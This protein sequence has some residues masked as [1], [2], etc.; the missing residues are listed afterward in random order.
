MKLRIVLGMLFILTLTVGAFAQGN[1]GGNSGNKGGGATQATITFGDCTARFVRSASGIINET[2]RTCEFFGFDGEDVKIQFRP[3]EGT[4]NPACDPE[5]LIVPVFTYNNATDGFA[6][7]AGIFGTETY[8][9]CAYL[10]PESGTI[11]STDAD[12]TTVT[13]DATGNYRVCVEGTYDF[14]TALPGQF[15]GDAE[16]VSTDGW[17]TATDKFAQFP[18]NYG[19]VTINGAFVNWGPYSSSHSYC[20]TVSGT[21]GST[22]NLEVYDTNYAD[23]SGTLTYT[24]KYLGM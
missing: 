23:N 8:N 21:A 16:F 1:K 18:E 11:D 14:N 12:G 15:L 20:T 3:L 9:V 17:V 22:L 10:N 19:E 24:L 2:N 4:P 5:G 13:L 7:L 6:S